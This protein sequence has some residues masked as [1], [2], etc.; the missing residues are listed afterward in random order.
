V[1]SALLLL[2]LA[3]CAAPAAP[4][5]VPVARDAAPVVQGAAG[6]AQAGLTAEVRAP[7]RVEVGEPFELTV[8]LG[9]PSGARPVLL[10]DAVGEGWVVLAEHGSVT[11]P[12]EAGDAAGPGREAT[13]V[14]WT[15]VALEPAAEGLPE[16]LAAYEGGALEA[17]YVEAGGIEVASALAP[18]EDAPRSVH[19]FRSGAGGAGGPRWWPWALVSAAIA[20]AAGAWLLRKR[21]GV[22][23]SPH[24]APGPRE[25]IG[26]IDPRALDAAGVRAAY[27]EVTAALREAFDRRL[28]VE[29][30]GCTDPEWLAAARASGKLAE[31]DLDLLSDLLRS[32]AAVKYGGAQPTHWAL[33]ETL[34]RARA[35]L[36]GATA[37]AAPAAEAVR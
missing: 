25:R 2:R 27:F 3:L 34:D 21:R 37:G 14:R 17:P 22:R 15:V 26:A 33:G 29:R 13:E 28:G 6:G 5:A 36:D 8:E 11:R 16:L 18:G 20:A 10:A 35:L 9:H 1:S 4:G 23:A 30:A 7:A 32:S 19:G 12:A 24:A 31:A